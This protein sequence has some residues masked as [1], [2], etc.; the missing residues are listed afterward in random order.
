MDGLNC[1]WSNTL[2]QINNKLYICTYDPT[3]LYLAGIRL[4]LHG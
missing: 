2:K 3:A 1:M 4:I